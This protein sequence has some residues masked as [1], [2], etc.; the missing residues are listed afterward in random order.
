MAAGRPL[1]MALREQRVWGVKERLFERVAAAAAPTTR[2]TQLLDAAQVC[3]GIVK[4]LKHPDWPTDRGSAAAARAD[5]GA[6][7]GARRRR[8]ARGRTAQRSR[9]SAV[10]WRFTSPRAAIDEVRQ[11]AAF[12]QC[13]TLAATTAAALRSSVS[14]ATCGSSV[15]RGCDQNGVPGRQRLAGEHVEH[16]MADLAR[17]SA[18]SRSASTTCAPRA[19][20]T[21]P[22]PRRIDA[23]TRAS[24]RPRVASVSGSRLTTMSASASAAPTR[25]CPRTFDGLREPH[26]TVEEMAAE[27]LAE[28]RT[29]RPHGPY[30]L[31]SLCAGVYIAAAMA[32]SLREAGETVLPLL[33]LDP[34]NSVLHRGYSQLTEQ[35]FVDK[36]KARRAKG[37]TAG[38]T[39]NP[40]YMQAVI[41]TAMAFEHAIANHRPVPYDGPVY[42]LSSRQ[43]MQGQDPLNL[44]AHLYRPVQTL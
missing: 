31:G 30:F 38:P 1:P 18:A 17:V 33:L 10:G 37:H 15:T 24:N 3:D 2:S 34:P 14:A 39:E 22:A 11:R 21:K 9:R 44:E 42:V 41:R 29:Q 7:D 40:A 13:T 32:R 5:A 12:A 19:R 27:Y 23:K 43:R 20:L 8:A 28:M 6:A 25:P 36:M 35:E 4:G 26:A 16:G